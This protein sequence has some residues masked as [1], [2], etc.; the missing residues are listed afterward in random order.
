MAKLNH[1]RCP[2]NGN[3]CSGGFQGESFST[4]SETAIEGLHL[5]TLKPRHHSYAL[6]SAA[7]LFLYL[8]L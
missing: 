6:L 1:L 3:M 5:A 8:I 2:G 7:I 4:D